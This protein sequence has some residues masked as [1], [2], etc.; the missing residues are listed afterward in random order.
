MILYM[1]T[2]RQQE[3]WITTNK[4]GQVGYYYF[5]TRAFRAFRMARDEAELKLATGAA[6]LVEKPFWVGA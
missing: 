4:R 5:S 3:L 2:T 1:N 6:V